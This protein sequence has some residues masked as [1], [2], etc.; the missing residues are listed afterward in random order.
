MY[1][2]PKVGYCTV[3]DVICCSIERTKSSCIA[4]FVNDSKSGN[5]VMKKIVVDDITR[6]CLFAVRS[7]EPG[8]ELQYDYGDQE[9]LFWRD[10]INI[11]SFKLRYNFCC[12]MK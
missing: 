12:S 1:M 8:V 9:S 6:L 5:C 4:Q 7:I 11:L 10:K 3:N 2:K